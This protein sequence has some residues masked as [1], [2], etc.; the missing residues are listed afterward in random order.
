MMSVW[1]DSLAI[2][3]GVLTNA[4]RRVFQLDVVVPPTP[5]QTLASTLLPQA[6]NS[7]LKP[8]PV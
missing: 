5:N 6:I 3:L 1:E 8:P 7:A 2:K 4:A